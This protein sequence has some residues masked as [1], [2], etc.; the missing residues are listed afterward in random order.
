[1]DLPARVQARV[2]HKWGFTLCRAHRHTHF[3]FSSKSWAHK[4]VLMCLTNQHDMH[5]KRAG[6]GVTQNM[7]THAHVAQRV[8]RV[9]GP[10]SPS[11]PIHFTF[12]YFFWYLHT[13]SDV[14]NAAKVSESSWDPAKRCGGRCRLQHG[15][16]DVGVK[17]TYRTFAPTHES[18]MK[19]F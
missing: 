19:R 8:V 16:G 4:V 1:M 3:P 2:Y 17:D 10:L 15:N 14:L 6:R 12:A 9:S 5:N 11:P 7:S 13:S 18:H